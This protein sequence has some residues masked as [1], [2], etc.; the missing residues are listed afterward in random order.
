NPSTVPLNDN[1][2]VILNL[3][4]LDNGIPIS[5]AESSFSVRYKT[6]AS[7]PAIWSMTP[8]SP[9]VYELI[10]DCFDVGVTGTNAL[11][12]SLSFPDY[13]TAEIQVPFQIRLRQG[14]LNELASPSTF[15]GEPTYVI[16]QL[17]DT[18]A[19]NAPISGATLSITWPDIGYTPDYVSIG[20]GR[21]NITLTT[22]SLDAGLYTLV[23][24]A[25][26]SDYFISDI[27]VPIQVLS[28]PT[29]LILPQSV[30][31]VYWGQ[32]VSVWAIFNNTRDNILLSG[33]T[34]VY[35]FGIL[36]GTLTEVIADPG[37]YTFSID[38][39]NLAL[40]TTYVVSVTATLTNYVTVTRQL[41]VNIQKLPIGLIVMSEAQPEVFKG[42]L[43][44]IT[45]F[46][47]N[48]NS[49]APLLGAT[50]EGTWIAQGPQSITLSPVPGMDGYYTGFVDTS[51][52]FVGEYVLTIKAD[53]ANYI[54]ATTS[55]SV[56]IKQIDTAVWLDTLTSTYSVKTF[57]WSDIIRIG[58]YVLAP[59]LNVS[60]PLSTG[61]A[62]CS[63]RWSLSGTAFTGEFLNG[64]SIGGPG[65]FYIDFE[66]WDYSASTYTLRITA[67]PNVG[68]FAY[69]S[70]TTTLIIEP[71]ETSVDSTYLSP[72]IWGWTG[73]INFTYWDLLF[74]RGIAGAS[75][76]VDWDGVESIFG[77]I[78]NGTYQIFI[79]ASLVSPGIYPVSVR[80]TMDNYKVGTGVFTLN[81]KEVPTSITAF[82]PEINQV[83]GEA[84]NLQ[85]PYGDVLPIVLFYN[86]T[87]YDRGI[88]GAT[89]MTGVILGQSILDRDYLLIE[90][91]AK[92][93]YSLLIDTTRW[94]VS[95]TPYRLILSIN[96]ANWSKATIEIHMTIINV[97]TALQIM[98]EVS[99]TMNYGQVYSIW[100]FYYDTWEGHENEG[101]AGA[102]INATSLDSRYVI[103]S[104]NQ[105][106]PSRP[107]WYEIRVSSLRIQGSAIVSVI[108]S[109]ENYES[110]SENIAIS[111]EPSEFDILLE[112]VVIYGVP[113]GI[114]IL[115]GAVLWN[116]LFSVPKR[117]R[118]IRGMVRT[119]SKGKIPQTPDNVKSRQE[120]VADLFNDIA[121]PIGIT[122]TASSMPSEAIATEVPEIEELLVQLSI[123]SKLTPEE[124][125]DFKLDVSKMKLS[126]QVN[127]V[128]E[129]LNQE[130]IKQGRI[131]RKPMETVLEETAIKARAILAGEEIEDVV[132]PELVVTRIEPEEMEEPKEPAEE[133]LDFE[134]LDSTDMLAEFELEDIRQKLI[135]AGIKGSEL[136]TI[137][138]QTRELPKELAEE[139]LRSILDKGGESE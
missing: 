107:G 36:S 119:I 48:T 66:T 21:Y 13:Q 3:N 22:A 137:M 138:E 20:P 117:L 47:N 64:T 28:I 108:L 86:D 49:N 120:I 63:V 60:Y 70:N 29:E 43:V 130:A 1:V 82:T 90:E 113:I 91:M 95:S 69:S 85:V 17:N 101:I 27:S 44:N 77:F 96:V 79:N 112:R 92:G 39:G 51:D 129:V 59:S 109:K 67:Y 105:S 19:G 139:L 50:V 62:N 135:K 104:L 8:I 56:R 122:K 134:E 6:N 118:E 131:E 26:I 123:L 10:V 46:V 72:K 94:V 61:L 75:A 65:Y 54:T 81:V 7:G 41:V 128:K 18:D 15:Y 89:E 37:N 93:N 14:E 106:D 76:F 23:V 78:G 68:M 125:E 98:G 45:V 80:F 103:V 116:R 97:P 114:I 24:G 73:W 87:L 11:I 40:A 111:V 34:L 74:D 133:P 102:S 110:A 121:G 2:S 127:F 53:R 42:T 84:L 132:E 88:P 55:V 115:V 25:Q 99:P 58:V 4:D 33:A 71:I 136:E 57:N 100:V 5:G 35:Q 124:L 31:D 30:P 126:E 52:L 38:T 32:D 9:G 12:V 16:V 83:D